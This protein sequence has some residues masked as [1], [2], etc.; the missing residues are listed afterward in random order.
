MDKE[1]LET[2]LKNVILGLTDGFSNKNKQ[3][4]K[5]IFKASAVESIGDPESIYFNYIYP[6]E[7]FIEGMISHEISDNSDLIYLMQNSH[8]IENH[9]REFIKKAEGFACCADKSRTIIK[10]L[11]YF[12]KDGKEVTRNW[13]QEFTFHYSK[14]FDNHKLIIDFFESIQDLQYGNHDKFLPMIQSLYI[15]TKVVKAKLIKEYQ[16]KKAQ[17]ENL[18]NSD[19]DNNKSE[20]DNV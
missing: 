10:D 7:N 19:Q 2:N 6:F 13:D 20:Q 18:I 16:D 12:Y 14:L 3:L 5:D 8:Y 17:T 9:Y 4:Y 1:I 15:K 11:F